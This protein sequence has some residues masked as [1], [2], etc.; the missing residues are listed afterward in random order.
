MIEEQRVVSSRIEEKELRSGDTRRM[1]RFGDLDRPKLSE[2]L[3]YRWASP[4]LAKSLRLLAVS[5]SQS[6]R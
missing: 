3:E 5:A 1:S 6:H 2:C 4:S